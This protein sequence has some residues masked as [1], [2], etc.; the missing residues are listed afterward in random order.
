MNIFPEK[1]SSEKEIPKIDSWAIRA[2]CR[3]CWFF[4]W[5]YGR[6]E[7]GPL[8]KKWR[9]NLNLLKMAPT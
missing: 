6:A 8:E 2:C 7:S 1:F 9:Q 5:E 4:C 3:S